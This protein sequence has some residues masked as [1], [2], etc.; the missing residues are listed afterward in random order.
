MPRPK[1][2]NGSSTA[3]CHGTVLLCMHEIYGLSATSTCLLLRER[4]NSGR[5]GQQA[6]FASAR[7]LQCNTC[8]ATLSIGASIAARDRHAAS[9]IRELQNPSQA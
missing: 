7:A 6:A 4:S 2:S 9:C 3:V 5:D 8:C 1:C